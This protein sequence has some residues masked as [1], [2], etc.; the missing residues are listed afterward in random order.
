MLNA[1]ICHRDLL[2]LCDNDIRKWIL[3]N[4]ILIKSSKTTILNCPL[5]DNTFSDI[6]FENH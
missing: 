1:E 6:I 4:T 3:H 2:M 5:L